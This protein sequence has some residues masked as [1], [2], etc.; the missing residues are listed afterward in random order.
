MQVSEND[1][2]NSFE[3]KTK[4]KM[5]TV[6]GSVSMSSAAGDILFKDF[7]DP[8]HVRVFKTSVSSGTYSIELPGVSVGAEAKEY[9]V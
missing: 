9:T 1:D 8:E 4:Y 6:S 2:G 3:L 5:V 7:S